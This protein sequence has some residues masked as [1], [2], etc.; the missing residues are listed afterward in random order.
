MKS[1]VLDD[2]IEYIIVK[3]LEIDGILYTLFSNINNEKDICFRKT[4]NEDGKEYYAG[5]DNQNELD[6][7]ILKFFKELNS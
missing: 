7:V 3:S 1:I 2:G 6:K 5:L 4:I